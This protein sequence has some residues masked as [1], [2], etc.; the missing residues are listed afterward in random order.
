VEQLDIFAALRARQAGQDLVITHSDADYREKLSTAI[1]VLAAGGSQFCSDD[2]RAMAGEPPAGFSHN[3]IG[4]LI[5]REL[6]AG[7]IHTVTWTRSS[8]VVGH[9]NLVGLYVGTRS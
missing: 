3:V 1:R 5:N 9:G 2:I 6:R 7:R 4:A 8:R